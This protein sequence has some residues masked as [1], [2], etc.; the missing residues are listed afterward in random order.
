MPGMGGASYSLDQDA[1]LMLHAYL[2]RAG[3]RLG[4]H[5][6]SDYETACELRAQVIDRGHAGET[7][8]EMHREIGELLRKR[9][10]APGEVRGL[11]EKTHRLLEESKATLARL[12]RIKTAGSAEMPG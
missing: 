11:H 7:W 12:D 1:F 6:E 3:E 4:K 5:P 2:D 10:P 8:N 9:T